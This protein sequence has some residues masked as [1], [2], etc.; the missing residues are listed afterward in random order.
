MPTTALIMLAAVYGLQALI[1]ILHR[2]FEVGESSGVGFVINSRT[3]FD[4][5]AYSILAGCLSV[6]TGSFL[7]GGADKK[8]NSIRGQTSSVSHSSRSSCE[9]NIGCHNFVLG[10]NY[11]V[12]SF[13]F[14]ARSIVS[15]M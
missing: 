9:Q 7:F 4:V 3:D 13:R 15:G 12:F 5:Y 11:V 10:A 1:F 6:R 8:T 2:K 14:S